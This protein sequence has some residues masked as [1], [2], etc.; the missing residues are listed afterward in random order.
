MEVMIIIIQ[1]HTQRTVVRIKIIMV[2]NMINTRA[3]NMINTQPINMM[4]GLT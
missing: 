4:N 3:F 1:R 2:L